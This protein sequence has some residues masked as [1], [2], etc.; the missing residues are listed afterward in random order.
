MKQAIVRIVIVFLAA[1]IF[2]TGLTVVAPSS[3]QIA[4]ANPCS[5]LDVTSNEDVDVECEFD[6]DVEI[7]AAAGNG[8]TGDE[9]PLSELPL[10]TQ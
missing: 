6:D 10:P 2:S 3:D 7:A 1:A 5:E 4:Q 8:L 9:I